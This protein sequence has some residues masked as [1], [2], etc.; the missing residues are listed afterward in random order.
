[1]Q[2]FCSV[3]SL[4]LCSWSCGFSWRFEGRLA[5]AQC[6]V[7]FRTLRN[8]TT[9]MWWWKGYSLA[10]YCGGLGSNP[11]QSLWDLWLVECHWD[12][13]FSDY[14]GFPQSYQFTIPP[15]AFIHLCHWHCVILTRLQKNLVAVMA[16]AMS[17]G[18]SVA[19]SIYGVSHG[20]LTFFKIR[21]KSWNSN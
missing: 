4:S 13:F 9:T 20:N 12:R 17:A 7:W 8:S 21:L 10:S 15:Y 2:E 18:H 16:F 14:I 11:G 6:C 5:P 19:L 1:M 3:V